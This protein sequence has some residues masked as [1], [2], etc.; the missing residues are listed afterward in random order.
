MFG[1]A[2]LMGLLPIMSWVA[3]VPWYRVVISVALSAA[4]LLAK[5][6]RSEAPSNIP[7]NERSRLQEEAQGAAFGRTRS[8]IARMNQGTRLGRLR[9]S[10][11]Q[12]WDCLPAPRV[13]NTADDIQN[14]HLS[15]AAAAELAF[16]RH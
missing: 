2:G 12:W 5:L 11:Q 3:P 14:L 8:G 1:G 6:R 13:R 15:Q 10:L 7:E 16:N 9:F 4:L